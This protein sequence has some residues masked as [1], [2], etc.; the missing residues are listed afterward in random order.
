MRNF[1][2]FKTITYYV[3]DKVD[4]FIRVYD[5]NRYLIY[6]ILFVPEK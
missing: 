4:E 6:L 2:W 5:G 3:D 1:N